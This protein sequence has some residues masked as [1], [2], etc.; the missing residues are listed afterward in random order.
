VLIDTAGIRKRGHVRETLERHGAVRALG[1]LVRTE[2]V[3]VV[4][5]AAEG[6]TDQDARLIG[7]AWEAGRG[8]ILLANKWDTVPPA[9]RDRVAF[10]RLVAEHRP[11]FAELPLLCVSAETGEGL[12]EL[13][14]TVARVERAYRAT[15]P[16]PALNRALAAAVQAQAPPS[17]GGRPVRLFYAAQTGHEPP[18]VT[19]FTSQRGPMQASYARFLGSR[20]MREF[21]LVGV[22][23]RLQFRPRRASEVPPPGI[24]ARARRSSPP[25]RAG[26]RP[27]RR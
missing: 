13:F 26:G 1:T 21:R 25:K 18:A 10:R 27:P 3:L 14:P 15:L 4:L 9:R 2:L 17:P 7:R 11:A 16:T 24:A 8:V 20:L 6:V 5:D 22:P 23:L 19:V 12:D